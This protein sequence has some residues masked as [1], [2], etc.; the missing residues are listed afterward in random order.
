MNELRENAVT[1]RWILYAPDRDRRPRDA[2]PPAAGTDSRPPRDDGC[3]F[4]PGNEEELLGILLETRG[5][6]GDGW[7][8]RVVPNKYPALEPDG[9]TDGVRAGPHRRARIGGRHEVVIE[10][11][12][13]DAGL[14][15]LDPLAGSRLVDTLRRRFHDLSAEEPGRR[16]LLFRNGGARAGASLHHPHTQ[17]VAFSGTPPAIGRREERARRYHRREDRCLVC[18]AVG[19]EE[20]AGLRVV[21]ADDDF[22]VHVPYAAEQPFELWIVPRRHA[23]D[24][25]SIDDAAAEAL[26]TALPRAA[27]LLRD[28][29]GGP[30]YNLILHSAPA[31]AAGDPA[32]HWW[33]QIRPRT[34]RRAGFE[35]GT[36]IDLNPSL[37]EADARTLRGEG[38]EGSGA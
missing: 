36:G 15:D 25:G 23:G 6:G 35:I 31:A 17:L 28:R 16:I 11:P 12:R 13:H 8:T 9:S 29:A 34:S 32:L 14:A 10:S 5:T 33:I 30:A 27:R 24:F 7:Q 20:D 21:D 22:V 2:P 1:G 26:S 4:C 3:P 37:P 19:W 18:D 38:G